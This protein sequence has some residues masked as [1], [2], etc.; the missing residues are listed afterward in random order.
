MCL[1]IDAGAMPAVFSKNHSKHDDFVL[2]KDW[3]EN[4]NGKVV[5][6]GTT[7]KKELKN[8]QRFLGVISEL[9]KKNRVLKQSKSLDSEIDEEEERIRKLVKTKDFDDPHL[10]AI[11][12]C[13]GVRIIASSDKRKD[14]YLK[15]KNLYRKGI[16]VP[17]MYSKADKHAGLLVEKN[18]ATCCKT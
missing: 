16:K 14:K 2:V 9:D 8:L 18:I 7:Y 17:K 4:G 5:Y 15:R 12:S 6:G 3:V 1:I 11:V 10:A 13:T